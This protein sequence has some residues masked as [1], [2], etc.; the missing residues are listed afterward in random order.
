MY[1]LHTAP[2]Q[3]GRALYLFTLH[4]H[5]HTHSLPIN[6]HPCVCPHGGLTGQLTARRGPQSA[7]LPLGAREAHSCPPVANQTSAPDAWAGWSCTSHG[8]EFAAFA[9]LLP[10]SRK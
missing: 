4:T 1:V 2:V 7:S 5:I 6:L 3:P 8:S 9:N 10:C